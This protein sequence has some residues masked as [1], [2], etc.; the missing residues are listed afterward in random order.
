[1]YPLT[2]FSWLTRIFHPVSTLIFITTGGA[3]PCNFWTST[4]KHIFYFIIGILRSRAI[5]WYINEFNRRRSG[6]GGGGG[7]VSTFWD[8]PSRILLGHF[9]LYLYIWN[10]QLEPSRLAPFL[11]KLGK[12][13]GLWTFPNVTGTHTRCRPRGESSQ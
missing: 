6:R 11:I 10:P 5:D 4:I 9:Q 1:M 12:R 3:R 7:G 13:G 2:E 8:P